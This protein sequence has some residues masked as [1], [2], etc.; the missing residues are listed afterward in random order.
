M[1]DFI[2][3]VFMAPRLFLSLVISL[4]PLCATTLLRK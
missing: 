2:G 1:V 4:G 3:V